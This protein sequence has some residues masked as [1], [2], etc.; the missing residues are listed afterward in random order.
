MSMIMSCYSIL[1][2]VVWKLL[3]VRL[4]KWTVIVPCLY[5]LVHAIDIN[6]IYS[7]RLR[8]SLR[9]KDKSIFDN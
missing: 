5:M 9:V 1:A 3:Q 7:D 4:R 8:P 6:L 2:I